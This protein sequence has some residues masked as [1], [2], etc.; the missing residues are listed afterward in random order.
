MGS[1]VE[2][3]M[4]SLHPFTGAVETGQNLILHGIALLKIGAVFTVLVEAMLYNKKGQ[5]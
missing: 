1:V 5:S 4:S 2:R 3:A